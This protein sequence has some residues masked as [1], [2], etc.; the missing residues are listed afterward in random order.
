VSRAFVKDDGGGDL[1]EPRLERR[2]SANPNYV[3]R[4]GL[5]R[6]REALRRAQESGDERSVRYLEGRI[7]TAILA[8]TEPTTSDVVEFGAFVTVHDQ[9]GATLSLQ[10]VGED[11]A[12]PR[13]GT[14]S[15]ESPIAQALTDHR[16]GDTVT[17]I[18]PAG[19]IAYTIDDVHYEG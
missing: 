16:P 6:L 11:E 18:R 3:T 8:D 10:I 15:W 13:H 19:P 1:P 9:Q 2:V 14:V 5:E 12:D 4:K 17:V 7:D